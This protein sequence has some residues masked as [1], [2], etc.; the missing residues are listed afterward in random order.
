M[1]FIRFLGFSSKGKGCYFAVRSG[2]AANDAYSTPNKNDERFTFR[3]RVVTG[4][5]C[6]GKENIKTLPAKPGGGFYD[7][8]V[9]S[10]TDPKMF[11]VFDDCA[12][13]PEYLIKF[14]TCG[15]VPST[16]TWG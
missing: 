3:V 7:S 12:A 1:V 15:N 14:K 2:Y 5:H 4:E 6:Q 9:D 10:M 13:Y 16:S 11:V 8:V